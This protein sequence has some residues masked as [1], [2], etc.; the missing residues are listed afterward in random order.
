[1]L[2]DKRAGVRSLVKPLLVR[3]G[4]ML[5]IAS[6]IV[7]H[8]MNAAINY[9][10]VGSWVQRHAPVHASVG[11]RN[12]VF[13][14]IAGE[15]K[16]R[17]ILYLEFGVWQGA[18]I[19]EWSRLLHDERATLHGFDSFEGL[20][21]DWNIAN[22]T[23]HFTTHG[24]V[25]QVRDERVRFF[26]GWFEETLKVYDPPSHDLLIINFDADLYSST[27]CV[28][29]KFEPMIVSGTYLYFDEFNDRKH[30]LAAFDEYVRRTGLRF[31]T[32]CATRE[33]SHI[34]FQVL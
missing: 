31:R 11:T 21:A 26:A 23:G 13:E 24:R 5:G 18:S 34:A 6:P 19:R 16:G 4:G 29:D 1:V 33:L 14:R 8:Q 25:P 7:G 32:V 15:V 12:Q 10:S 3:V 22:P 30:E 28:L 2:V 17:H 9:I 27:K 20:P